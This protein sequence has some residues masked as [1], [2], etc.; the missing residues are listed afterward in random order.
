MIKTMKSI[1]IDSNALTFFV[2][3]IEVGYDPALDQ[4]DIATEKV[5]ILRI[6]FYT[7]EPYYVVPMV[8]KEYRDIIDR[9]KKNDHEDVHSVLM[10]D[11]IDEIDDKDIKKR[12]DFYFQ[13]HP[14]IED[15]RILAEAELAGLDI[16]LTFD[17]KLINRLKHITKS[18]I[19]LRPS[20]YW[21]MLDIA[22]GTRPLVSPHRTNPLSRKNW[23]VI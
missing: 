9:I 10:Q 1:A 12:F 15:C 6:Y 22:S 11:F 3:A 14:C 16:L 5:A 18:I 8:E 20:E 17:K 7:G 13:C 2:D 23:W 19:I 4:A 21:T